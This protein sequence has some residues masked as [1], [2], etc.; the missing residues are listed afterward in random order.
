[1]ET[2]MTRPISTTIGSPRG[3]KRLEERAAICF[4]TCHSGGHALASGEKRPHSSKSSCG[5]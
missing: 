5:P 4:S 2:V 1:M 3:D